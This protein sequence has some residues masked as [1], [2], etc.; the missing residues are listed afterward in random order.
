VKVTITRRAERALERID[1]RWHALADHPRTFA[2]EFETARDALGKEPTPGLGNATSRR[3]TL[4]RL[5]LPKSGCHIY[6]TVDPARRWIEIVDI[7]DA[8]RVRSPRL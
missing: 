7:W 3:P 2:D 8:R 4:R 5:L 6:F 1:R